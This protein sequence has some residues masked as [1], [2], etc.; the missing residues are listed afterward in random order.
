MNFFTSTFL[1]S[2]PSYCF[3][4]ALK[5][6]WKPP[7]SVAMLLDVMLGVIKEFTTTGR[8][9]NE[10]LPKLWICF[11][12]LRTAETNILELCIIFFSYCNKLSESTPNSIIRPSIRQTKFQRKHLEYCTEFQSCFCNNSK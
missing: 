7:S 2:V 3:L 4:M 9:I 12:V 6:S 1:V 5:S 10:D 11:G 8:L